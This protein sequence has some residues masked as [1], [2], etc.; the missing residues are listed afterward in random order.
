MLSDGELLR[1]YADDGSEAAFTELVQRHI[2]VVYAAALRRVGRNAH[3]ADDVTQR[4][5]SD[6]ARKA[7]TLQHRANLAGW[8]YTGTRFAA[9]EV[10]RSEQ[11]RRTHEQEAHTMREINSTPPLATE[12]FEPF[13][14]EIMDLLDERDRDAILLHF[15]EGHS[16]AETGAALSLSADAA[17]MRVNRALDRLRAALAQRGIASTST[18]LA[19]ALGTQ[20][21]LAAPARLALAVAGHAL[22]QAGTAPAVSLVARA[23][24]AAKS[25][26]LLSA[27]AVLLVG[28]A[29]YS[30]WS[31]GAAESETL[32]M[33][34]P[35]A[36]AAA[37]PAAEAESL[38]TP[39]PEPTAKQNPQVAT[40]EN[41]AP[42][43]SSMNTPLGN[44]SPQELNLLVRL[45]TE[46][47]NQGIGWGLRV[48]RFA[49]NFSGEA[50]LIARGWARLV[51]NRGVLA[52]TKAG[53]VY[54]KAH[55]AELDALR[56]R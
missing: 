23:F 16:F 50:P 19:V 49:P 47:E 15:F 22:R 46:R 7:K 27:G 20:S 42:L 5:F 14:D 10:V 39:V 55:Q 11:R 56:P 29:G 31:H 4:V 52:L 37:T 43:P 26:A 38:A 40:I 2:N 34:A 21:A 24:H 41:S 30:T 48:G 25:P 35:I 51:T 45:W 9:A 1:R 12:R 28:I 33:T 6:L 32:P 18:A 17:R 53:E 13:L 36:I 3:A 54:C 44:L 8:L